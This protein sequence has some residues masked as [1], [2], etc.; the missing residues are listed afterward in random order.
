VQK[1]PI[2]DDAPLYHCQPMICWGC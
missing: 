1:N 2:L